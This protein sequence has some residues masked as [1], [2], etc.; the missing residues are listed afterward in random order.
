VVPRDRN[1]PGFM[2]APPIALQ[3][4]LECGMDEL[5]YASEMDRSSCGASTTP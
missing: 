1:T 3:F 2:R 5:A 4:A